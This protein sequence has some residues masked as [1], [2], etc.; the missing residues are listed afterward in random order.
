MVH[1]LEH[2][3][4]NRKAIKVREAQNLIASHI[5][6]IEI[7]SVDLQESHGRTLAQTI[8]APHPYPAFRRSMMDGYAICSTDT[9]QCS[10]ELPVWLEVIDDIPCGTVS[11]KMIAPGTTARIMT[12]AQVPEGADAVIMFEKVELREKN[13]ITWAGLS[14]HIEQ[15]SSITP[16]GLELQAEEEILKQGDTIEAGEISVLATFGIHR[17][18]VYRRPRVAI[19]S[20]GSE[21]LKIDE[22]LQPGKIRNSNTYMIASQVLEAGG[23]PV[24][25]DA[26]MDDL[27]LAQSK[28]EE[29]LMEYD[30]VVT[31]GGVSVGDYD[32][33]GD[34][35]RTD[36]VTMLYNKVSMRPGSVSTAAIK[37]GKCL[38]ALSGNPGACFVGFELFVRPSIRMMMLDPNPYLPEWT[39]TLGA[40]Y[41]KIN[42][43]TRFVR[44]KI[45]VREGVVFAT[46]TGVDES[47]VMITIKDSDC[48]IIVPPAQEGLKA[49]VKVT[50]IVLKTEHKG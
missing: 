46:P 27:S 28:V 43:F 10:S 49:G 34:L 31:S 14:T 15:G 2:S 13:G 36:C 3:K 41:D 48:F 37:D 4:F 35:V 38:F 39:A 8:R 11:N 44:A 19:F 24:I 16:I 7:E 26:I 32:I 20:T 33:M 12:G 47:G 5:H 21:L 9:I 18:E 25:L 6:P 29:A 42:S 22:P 50:I 23:E 45:Q 17:V 40:D 1:S 30:M